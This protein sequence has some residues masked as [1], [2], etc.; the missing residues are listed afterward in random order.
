MLRWN[1]ETTWDSLETCDFRLG[2][3]LATRTT[4][5]QRSTSKPKV[6]AKDKSSCESR[7]GFV[8]L[9][10]SFPLWFFNDEII[11]LHFIAFI[12]EIGIGT[13]TDHFQSEPGGLRN[14]KF[15][16]LETSDFRQPVNTLDFPVLTVL[17]QISH[18]SKIMSAVSSTVPVT[19]WVKCCSPAKPSPYQIAVQQCRRLRG[20]RAMI[21]PSWWR[22]FKH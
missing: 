17:I 7:A 8:V 16:N 15:L 22:A 9:C 5:V 13:D 14:P 11:A 20:L 3:R 19:F 1:I 18:S 2:P 12:C 4:A 21:L 10:L 6:C